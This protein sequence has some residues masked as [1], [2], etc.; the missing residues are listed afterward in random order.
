MP[1]CSSVVRTYSR[2]GSF[3]DF[4]GMFCSLCFQEIILVATFSIEYLLRLWSSSSHGSYSG[5]NGKLKFARKPYMLIGM[6]NC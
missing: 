6:F 5:C 4:Y 3:K 2:G 1:S